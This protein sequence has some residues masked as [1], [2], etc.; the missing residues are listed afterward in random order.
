[1]SARIRWRIA[2]S[3][4]VLAWF[5]YFCWDSALVH[6]APDDLMNLWYYWSAKPGELLLS[7]LRPWQ[8]SYRHMAALYYL[9][10]FGIF[11]LNPVPFH[12]V[13]LLLLLVNVWLLWRLASLLGAGDLAAWLAALLACYHSGLAN[14]W[15]DTAFIFDVLCTLF[16]LSAVVWH[17]RIRARGQ[18]PNG[19]QIA[20]LLGL[21][22]CALN[23]KEMA[24]TLPVVLFAYEWTYHRPRWNRKE[25]RTWLRGPGRVVMWTAVLDALYLYGKMLRPGALANNSAYKPVFS[26]ARFGEFQ[27]QSWSDL[28]AW[29]NHLTT[30]TVLAIWLALTLIAWLRKKPV[31]RFCWIWLLVT[32]LPIEFLF[33]RVGACL[34][35]PYCALAIFSAVVFV[36]AARAL[37]TMARWRPLVAPLCLMGLFFWAMHHAHVKRVAVL[38]AMNHTGRQSWEVIE[39]LRA[40]HPRVRPRS[41]VVFRDDPFQGYDMAFIAALWFRDRS[42]QIQLDRMTPL[43][44]QE[45]QKANYVF[46]FE[47]G[48]MVQ[49]R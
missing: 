48:R 44:A 26:L 46:A 45:L 24:V 32:P 35:I 27:V 11:G 22:L 10:L 41:T 25:L 2:G 38:P 23:S 13:T 36:D 15:Y 20:V 12:V 49:L 9:P 21:F 14:L 3:L 40:L 16:F 7:M 4:F 29:W 28:L 30:G 5:V 33:Q 18:A 34:M 1:L 19:R 8:G 43:S 17:I 31:L 37:A 47:G 42:L 6:F 39:Q